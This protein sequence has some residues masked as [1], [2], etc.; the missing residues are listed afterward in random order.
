[1][2]KALPALALAAALLTAGCSSTVT[3][4]AQN[5]PPAPAASSPAPASKAPLDA[6][7]VTEKLAAAIPTVKL[8]VVYDAA[9]DP[10][11]K[12]G[13]PNQYTSKTAFDDSR[14]SSNPKAADDAHGRK[15]DIAYG[16]TV[17]VFASD[18][19]AAAWEK[20]V[21]TITKSV[22]GLITPDYVYR[23]GKVVIRV[24]HLLT[25]DQAAEYDKAAAQLG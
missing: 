22:G 18:D 10:N 12:L 25:P 23:H 17:E 13:R 16:G 7:A 21:T 3:T 14:A 4:S 15:N 19:D 2:R 6:K 24:S 9:T 11:G 8:T 1:M 20:Y 5:E